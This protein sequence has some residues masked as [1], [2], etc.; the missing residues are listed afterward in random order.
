[1]QLSLDTIHARY[2]STLIPGRPLLG[3]VIAG[4]F[5]F[6]TVRFSTFRQVFALNLQEGYRTVLFC[7]TYTGKGL[8]HNKS[9]VLLWH[10]AP[11]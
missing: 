7:D 10:R 1:M 9:V 11:Q 5:I 2:L 6:T 8:K 4:V 3:V